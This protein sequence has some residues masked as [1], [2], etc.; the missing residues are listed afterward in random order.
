MLPILFAA[1]T[2]EQLNSE[3]DS[4]LTLPPTDTSSPDTDTASTDDT[5]VT[6]E[7]CTDGILESSRLLLGRKLCLSF[8]DVAS[9]VGLTDSS[10][11]TG[12]SVIDY[13]QDS[14]QDVFLLN[15][16]APNSLFRNTGSGTFQNVTAASGLDGFDSADPTFWHDAAW[17]DYDDDTDLDLALAGSDGCKIFKNSAGHFAELISPDGLENNEPCKAVAWLGSDIVFGTING[18]RL[19]TYV[20]GDSF[21]D[22]TSTSGLIDINETADI[23]I[24]DY[25][26]DSRQDI[27][28]GNTTGS[29]RI[30]H[31]NGDQNFTSLE[32]TLGMTDDNGNATTHVDWV[33]MQSGELPALSVSKYGSDSFYANLQ[34]GTFAEQSD[35]LGLSDPGNTSTSTFADFLNEGIPAVFKGRID[36]Q[37]L[38]LIANQTEDLSYSYYTDYAYQLGMAETAITTESA[39]I[40][41]DDDG[42]LDILSVDYEGGIHLY[43][44]LTHEIE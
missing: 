34:N 6:T 44:N 27:A 16:G 7:S 22:V 26:G 35:I 5:G 14:F 38:F 42:N 43:R 12:L 20:G 8:E 3:H 17:N 2:S 24:A 9:T 1:C 23:A 28:V 18:L 29:N 19:Q 33:T 39:A 30:F 4:P 10:S 37:P 31:N 36:A 13:D 21:T 32:D 25:D 15:Y 41:Y 11:H 40:D